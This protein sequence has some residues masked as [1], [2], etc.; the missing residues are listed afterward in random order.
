MCAGAILQAR[1]KRVVFGAHDP[2]AG[3]AGSVADLFA[4]GQLNHQTQIEGGLMA[5]ACSTVL[6]DFFRQQRHA[7]RQ[8]RAQ[9]GRALRDDALRTPEDC[10]AGLPQL[11]ASSHYLSDLPSLS[12]LRLH[13]VDTGPADAVRTPAGDAFAGKTDGP[14]LDRFQPAD[15]AQRRGLAHAVA[16]EQCGRFT[17]RHREIDAEQYLAGAVGD[18]EGADFEQGAHRWSPR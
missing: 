12:G 7:Q 1:L 8:D 3:A 17:F 18:F 6:Q 16:A 9:T 4:H 11:P 14:G 10:F 15:G 2:K 5:E 13:Y